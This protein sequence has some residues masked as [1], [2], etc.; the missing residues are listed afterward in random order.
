M[1]REKRTELEI[2]LGHGNDH[3]DDDDEKYHVANFG[4]ELAGRWLGWVWGWVVR[5]RWRSVR[6]CIFSR[7]RNETIMEKK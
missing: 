7:G 6:G 2:F 5:G 3:E 4:G 1:R